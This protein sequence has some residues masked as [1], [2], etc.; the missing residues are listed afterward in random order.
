MVEQDRLSKVLLVGMRTQ[1]EQADQD[2]TLEVEQLTTGTAMCSLA[3]LSM[4]QTDPTSVC[5]MTVNRQV[6]SWDRLQAQSAEDK[7]TSTLA[8]L[9]NQGLPENRDMWPEMI[10]DFY[11]VRSELSTIGPVVLCGDRVV[12]PSSLQS[13]VLEVLHAAHQG[14]TGMTNR[15]MSSVYWPGMTVDISRTRAACSSCDKSAPSQ[16]HAPPTPL[17]HPSYPFDHRPQDTLHHVWH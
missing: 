4:A 5:S 8:E 12:I 15:A 13:E 2:A 6:I 1:P 3:S 7:A 9:I 10:K 11:S 16:P 14:T 17:S